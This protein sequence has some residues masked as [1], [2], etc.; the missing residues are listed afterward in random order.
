MS[1]SYP[2]KEN[3]AL[4][5][6]DVPINISSSVSS[7]MTNSSISLSNESPQLPANRRVVK[8][9]FWSTTIFSI[10]FVSS[11]LVINLAKW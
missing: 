9:C 8:S 7:L 4:V 11:I 3:Q 6:T 1:Y 10:N 5:N 2:A